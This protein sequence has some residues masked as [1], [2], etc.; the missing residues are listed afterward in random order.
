MQQANQPFFHTG[1]DG[2]DHLVAK[3]DL[4]G[5]KDPVVKGREEFFT[6]V[7]NPD[8]PEP[9]T[10]KA[11]EPKGDAARITTAKPTTSK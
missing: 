8:K 10:R 2:V 1:K 4:V 5:D 6:S 11:A 3:G 9:K 7:E